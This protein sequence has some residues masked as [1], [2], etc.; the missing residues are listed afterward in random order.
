VRPALAAL[1]VLLA[2]ACEGKP[3][4]HVTA[5]GQVDDFAYQLQGVDLGELG[6]TRFDLAVIDYSRD[7]SDDARFTAAEIAQLK[8]SPGGTKLVLAYMSIGEAEDY[9]WYWQET[10]DADHDG[11]PDAGAPAWLGPS[12]PDWPGNYK[13]R[14]WEP[15]WQQVILGGSGYLA[16]VVAAGFDGVYLDVIDAYEYWGPGGESGLE[17]P[18]AE[19]EMVDFVRLIAAA[20]PAGFGVFP[21]NGEGLGT[22][23]EYLDAVTG[24]GREDVWYNDNEAQ[25]PAQ[26]DTVLA[27]LERFRAAGKLVLVID[28]VTRPDLIDDFYE[29]A[30]SRGF[31]PY[32]T[33][34]D[35]D[36]LTVNA[37]H[38]P[39]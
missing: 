9:R 11:T 24:I 13:V 5:W 36:R 25:P 23:G 18:T 38:E 2:L 29:R 20:A 4:D 26:T 12:N 30:K 34:R 15:E 10:W 22:H 27:G 8:A 37:G 28:Y 19:Q 39:D 35:L 33:V 32:A 3:D 6:A 17:R 7:G 21:Q 16:K 1:S 14:Y 31:V